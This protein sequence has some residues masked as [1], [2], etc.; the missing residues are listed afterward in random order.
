VKKKLKYSYILIAR[1]QGE[2]YSISPRK[3]VD[4][5]KKDVYSINII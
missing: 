2:R 3:Y 1:N 4:M 5:K